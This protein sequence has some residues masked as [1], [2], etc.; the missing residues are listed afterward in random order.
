MT[1][2]VLVVAVAGGLGAALRL[3][4][5]ALVHRRVSTS[6]PVALFGVNVTGS[7]T[8]GLLSG[9][10]TAHVLPGTVG[11]YLGAGLVGGF[12]AFSTTSFQT[13]RL[14]QERRYGLAVLNSFGM[15]A[16]AVLAAALGLWLGRT[17]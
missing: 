15:L 6:Y 12:T 14:L 17:L 16:G 7:F 11:A 3:T 13:M 4:V 2:S 5:N 8:L 1:W 9:L 10:L